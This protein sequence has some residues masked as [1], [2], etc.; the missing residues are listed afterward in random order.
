MLLSG[1]S[2]ARARAAPVSI[3][4]LIQRSWIEL[5]GLSEKKN[6]PTNTTNRVEMLTVS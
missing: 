3:I 5:N 6:T 4:R 2:V 1:G